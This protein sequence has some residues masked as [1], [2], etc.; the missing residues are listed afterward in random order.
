MGGILL[1]VNLI[2]MEAKSKEMEN[3]FWGYAFDSKETDYIYTGYNVYWKTF[4]ISTH[5][6]PGL[7]NESRC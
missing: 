4:S 3:C 7:P 5:F 1:L 6:S 2:N